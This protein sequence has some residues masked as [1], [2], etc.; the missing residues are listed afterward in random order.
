MKEIVLRNGIEFADYPFWAPWRYWTEYYK[1]DGQ[2]FSEYQ[3]ILESPKYRFQVM[4]DADHA[5]QIHD[6]DLALKLYQEVIDSKTLDWWSDA[7]MEYLG[8]TNGG[9]RGKKPADLKAP[10]P[11]PN[12]YPNLAAYTRYRLMILHILRGSMPEAQAAYQD[13]Q[14]RYTEGTPG[15]IYAQMAQAFWTDYAAAHDVTEA[16]GKSL[17]VAVNH[18]KEAFQYLRDNYSDGW[19]RTYSIDQLCPYKHFSVNDNAYSTLNFGSARAR[20]D[21]PTNRWLPR[22]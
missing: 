14:Q 11:D 8:W 17:A 5:V 22:V 21:L 3:R 6:Y 2:Y 1:W 12:E 4:N 9:F 7:R 18:E 13:L 10:S 19:K 15:S 20:I 16:C